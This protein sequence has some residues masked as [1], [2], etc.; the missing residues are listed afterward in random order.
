M[1]KVTLAGLT[2]CQ[3]Y[4]RGFCLFFF[5]RSNDISDYP[6]RCILQDSQAL[7]KFEIFLFFCAFLHQKRWA[8][9]V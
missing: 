9:S 8:F 2:V 4:F 5:V 7:L 1:I 3:I 6:S